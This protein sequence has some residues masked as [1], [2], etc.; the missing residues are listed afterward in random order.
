MFMTLSSIMGVTE[1][2]FTFLFVFMGISKITY[3]ENSLN[4]V[5]NNVSC[6]GFNPKM[7]NSEI[8]I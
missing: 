7:A 3:L 8:I 4:Y 5:S 1:A 2:L 6:F